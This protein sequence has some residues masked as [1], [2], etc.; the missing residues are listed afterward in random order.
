MAGRKSDFTLPKFDD[1]FSTQEMR[2]DEKLAKIRDIPIELIDNF[3]NHPYRVQDDED[4]DRLVESI[5]ERGVI[6]PAMV[7]Q[8]ED[9]RYELVSGHRRK[10]ACELA[11]FETLRCEVVELTRDEAIILMVESNYQRTQQLPSERAFAYKMRLEAL[12]RQGK[13]TDLTCA[14]ELHKSDGTK[15]RD[16]VADKSGETV[17]RYIRLTN[18]IPELLEMVDNSVVKDKESLQMAL[19]P[20][21]ELS[22]LNEDCQRDV[23]DEIDLND[24]TPSHDQ[25]IRMRKMFEQGKLTPEAIQA[26]MSEQKPNQRE[27]IVLRGDRVRQFIPK[28]IPLSQTEDFVCKALEHYSAYLR[29]RSERDVR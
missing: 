14:T 4:M 17:R 16:V 21:V 11:G 10:R 13:R 28:N 20:A 6:T 2:D 25:T 8:K 9:G 26:I 3:P 23:V 15:S 5:K 24:C 22:Y 29:K 27:K 19:K 12:A 1:I 18:L 7:R